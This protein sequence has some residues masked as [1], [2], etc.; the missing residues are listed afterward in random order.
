[1]VTSETLQLYSQGYNKD[2]ICQFKNYISSIQDQFIVIAKRGGYKCDILYDTIRSSTSGL[3][4]ADNIDHLELL[5]TVLSDYTITC[6]MSSSGPI[7][8]IS[9]EKYI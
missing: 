4:G 2:A 5:K 3:Q 9:W 6:E 8:R 7:V 1:M